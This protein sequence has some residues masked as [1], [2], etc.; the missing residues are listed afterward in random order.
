MVLRNCAEV[1]AQVCESSEGNN[2]SSELGLAELCSLPLPLGWVPV[3][4]CYLDR[5][6]VPW[7]CFGWR[8][9]NR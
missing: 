2:G 9:S 6:A 7:S 1:W 8:A 4:S 3:P 5:E